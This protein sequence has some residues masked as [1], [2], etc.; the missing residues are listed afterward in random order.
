MGFSIQDNLKKINSRI[1]LSALVSLLVTTFFLTSFI[2]FLDAKEKRNDQP[3]SY[4]E[5]RIENTPE[6]VV[7]SKP[8]G[9]IS[10]TTYTFSW[11]QGSNRILPKNR[12]YFSNE[13]EAQTSKRTLSKLCK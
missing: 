12:V 10:G 5:G 2:I 11:C 3:I 9:S 6:K 1:P 4:T 7:D 8:F 13:Q